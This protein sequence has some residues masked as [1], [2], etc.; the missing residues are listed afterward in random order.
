ML[1]RLPESGVPWPFHGRPPGR[2]LS[3]SAFELRILG[4]TELVGPDT[5]DP[6]TVVRQSKRL[7]LLAYLALGTVD[8]FR[9]RDQIM[10]LFWPELDQ[11][12]ARANLRK[13]LHGIRES[14]GDDLFITR[15]E[16]EIRVDGE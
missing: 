1:A 10:G 12:S 13:A 4:S 7:A 11:S 3:K 6:A 14:L 15:G 5:A 9:R 8:G 2:I 16:D